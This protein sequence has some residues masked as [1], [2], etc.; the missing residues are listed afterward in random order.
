MAKVSA[1]QDPVWTDAADTCVGC[2]YSLSGLSAPGRCPECGAPYGTGQ[3]VLTGIV[4]VSRPTSPFR[5]AA[6]LAV[7]GGAVL[8]SM[9]W[10]ILLAFQ[11]VLLL[12]LFLAM[13]G[14]IIALWVTGPRERSG[15]ERLVLTPAGI[16]RI[17]LRAASDRAAW[18]SLFTPFDGANSVE[19]KRVSP[20]WRQVRLSVVTP[21]PAGTGSR[22]N[23]RRVFEAGFR[24]ADSHAPEVERVVR[25]FVQGALNA[26]AT[27]P[28]RP[29]PAHATA[30][31]K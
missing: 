27:H 18:D 9:L 22:P 24:C 17:A 26:G 23:R 30:G 15:V 2:G 11:A 31:G 10:P 21:G 14:G 6:W 12:V 29:P 1:L 7:I 8:L 25:E 3:L 20:V 13:V 5:R 4:R 28:D 19:F 16:A